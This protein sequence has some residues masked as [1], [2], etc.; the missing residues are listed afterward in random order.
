MISK[1]PNRTILRFELKESDANYVA[2]RKK[3]GKK[4]SLI[5]AAVHRIIKSKQ[6]P[7]DMNVLNA[8]ICKVKNELVIVLE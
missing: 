8:S 2:S 1:P 6:L 7:N 3:K 5:G 4:I